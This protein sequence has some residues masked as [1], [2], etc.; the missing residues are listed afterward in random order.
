MNHLE[1][2]VL[3]LHEDGPVPPA[4]LLVP[5]GVGRQGL[6]GAHLASRP[7]SLHLQ[8]QLV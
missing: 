7:G 3:E 1:L 8:G 2:R 4:L 5:E 6:Q